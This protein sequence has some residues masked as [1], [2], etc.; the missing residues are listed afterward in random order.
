MALFIH[1]SSNIRYPGSPRLRALASPRQT[2]TS[3]VDVGE[4]RSPGHG[5][6]LQSHLAAGDTVDPPTQAVSFS[7]KGCKAR[8]ESA[9]AD[10]SFRFGILMYL[11]VPMGEHG[12]SLRQFSPPADDAKRSRTGANGL[13]HG[14]HHAESVCH[15]AGC[16]GMSGM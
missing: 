15:G 12:A 7:R 6:V 2:S 10:Q 8:K 4:R 3:F 13:M 9:H 1:S 14:R 5:S 11:A 16:M